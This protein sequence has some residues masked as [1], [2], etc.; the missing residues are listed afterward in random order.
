MF[1]DAAR[2]NKLQMIYRTVGLEK[3]V[4]SKGRR[5][6]RECCGGDPY[7]T[8]HVDVYPF[9][10]IGKAV[11]KFKECKRHGSKQL[12]AWVPEQVNGIHGTP[13]PVTA[14]RGNE[15]FARLAQMEI[16]L[17]SWK[18]FASSASAG[19]ST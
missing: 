15:V 7:G 16:L 9:Y 13:N 2:C 12:P 14:S 4:Y 18:A 10:D 8:N 5:R 17:S 3:L 6:T 1:Q 19:A 11:K